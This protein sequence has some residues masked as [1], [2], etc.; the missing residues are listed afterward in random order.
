MHTFAQSIRLSGTVFDAETQNFVSGISI[1]TKDN[2]TGT[3]STAK[4]K[5]SLEIPA[6]KTNGYL[7]FTSVGYE[8]DSLLIA[9][10]SNPLSIKLKPTTYLLKEFYV[11]PDSTLLT[12]LRKAYNKIPE[13]Y[14]AQP[15]RYE[16]FFQESTS[17][18]KDSLVEI[19]EAVLSVYKESYKGKKEAPGQ[20]EILKSRNKQIQDTRVGFIGGAF[21]PITNDLVLQRANYINPKMMQYRHYEFNGI[22]TWNGMDCYEIA[23]RPLGKDSDNVQG[24]MLIDTETLAY[25]SFNMH[26]EHPENAK[27]IIGPMSPVES[28]MNVIYEKQNEKWYLKQVKANSKH[29]NWRITGSLYSSY[30]FVTTAIQTDS[31]KPIPIEKRLEYLDP[32]ETKTE[33]YNPNGWTDSDI[34]AKEDVKQ[35]NFQFSTDEAFSIFQQNTPKKFSFTKTLITIVPK[36]IMGYGLNYDLNQQLLVFQGIL[37][38]KFN[39]KWNVRWQIAE[40]FF[41]KQINFTENSLGIEFRKNLNNAGRPV[42][43]G[44]SLWISDKQYTGK[45]NFKEQTITPQLSFSKRMST[46]VTLEFFANY[47]ITIHSKGERN[48]LSDYPNF[49][50]MFY[51]F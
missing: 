14:P 36:L 10:A 8:T 48:I 29:E 20:I 42:F 6:H 33:V 21:L 47:P 46:F 13:N 49:G 39:R 16:G 11:M 7:Y 34:L 32:I 12:L 45:Y 31:V 43:L 37:G 25:V 23:F 5:F 3:I 18:E 2:Q 26:S 44:T 30:A 1:H 22:K 35:L 17:N 4:G 41:D 9:K 15:T 51:V 38:Y 50:V 24:T 19:I 27:K 40:D 28:K